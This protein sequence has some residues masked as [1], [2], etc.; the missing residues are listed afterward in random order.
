MLSEPPSLQ[1]QQLGVRVFLPPEQHRPRKLPKSGDGRGGAK[2]TGAGDATEAE[3]LW[4][5]RRGCCRSPDDPAPDPTSE[6]KEE[7]KMRQVQC[8]QW[9][10]RGPRDLWG[11][12][13]GS[14]GE[15]PRE[16]EGEPA[17]WQGSA[18]GG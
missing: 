2:R 16:A 18:R 14:P 1:Q 5:D 3:F 4:L 13:L 6:R 10:L 8:D 7:A 9:N 11:G 15:A 12:G 17:G